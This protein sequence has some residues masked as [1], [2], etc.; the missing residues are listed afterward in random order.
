MALGLTL[1]FSFVKPSSTET[2]GLVPSIF[3]KLE[4]LTI[5]FRAYRALY[6]IDELASILA[7][8]SS[9]SVLY[10][11]YFFGDLNLNSGNKGLMRQ[12]QRDGSTDSLDELRAR[13]KSAVLLPISR[14]AKQ[15]RTLESIHIDD[16][17]HSEFDDHSPRKSWNVKGWLRVLNGNRDVGGTLSVTCIH[18]RS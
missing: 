2:L 4:V 7:H 14:L 3:P 1:R 9:L 11:K 6:D 16:I 8:F 5:D 12:V 17:G 13:V 18:P 15:A 10:L